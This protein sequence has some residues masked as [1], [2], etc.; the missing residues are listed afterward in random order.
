MELQGRLAVVT[1]GGSG[2]GRACAEAFATAGAKEVI[3]VDLDLGKAEHVADTIGTQGVAVGVDVANEKDL[4]QMCSR[5]QADHGP[6][7]LF[8]SN[9]GY[10]IQG[11]LDLPTSQWQR[12]F[13]VHFSSHLTVARALI[14][15]MVDRGEGY[16]VSTASAAGMLTQLDSGP[17][18][19]SKAAAIS[20][21]QWLAI[22]YGHRGVKV[23]V[24]CP[25]A[26]RTNIVG[27]DLS[28]WDDPASSQASQDGVLE[29]EEIAAAVL[30]TIRK[31]E[32]LCLPHD[33]V[34][35]Y[36]QR[37]LADPDRWIAGMQRFRERLSQAGAY[38]V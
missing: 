4:T 21:A 33:R 26:V 36:A 3:V 23:S 12:M 38:V 24:I 32:F 11:G 14:P 22:N 6:I 37:R 10:L 13:D 1:G 31:E 2:I 7:D 35:D 15:S 29:P 16:L 25:Q 5:I 17:Y 30:E 19:V 34:L 27:D 8:L 9:A 18:S 28:V 20:F